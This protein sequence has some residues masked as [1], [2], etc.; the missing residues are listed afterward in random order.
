MSLKV[1]PVD[2]IPGD[3]VRVARAAFPKGSHAM[4]LRDKLGSVYQDARFA[5]LFAVRG[6]P[7]EAP[8]RLAVVTVLQFAEGLSDRQAANAVR[9]RIDWKYALGLTLDDPG[10]HYSVLCEFRGRLIAGNLE[11]LLLEELLTV[12]Q[13]H[14]LLRRRGRQRTDSTHILGALRVLSRLEQVAETM[15]AALNALAVTDP[16]WLLAQTPADW[17]ERYQRRVEEYRLP[18]GREAREVFARQVGED[19]MRLLTDL[20]APEAPLALRQLP[21]VDILRRT[22]IQ[23][24][25]VWEGQVRLRTPEEQPPSSDQIV[26]PYEDEARYAAKQ[27]LN[28]VGYKTHL[29]ETCDD[30][31]PHL[32]TD[33]STTIAPTPDVEQLA[34][35]QKR[36]VARALPPSEHFVD[37]GYVRT[38]N[39][40]ASQQEH[41]IDLIGPIYADRQWQAKAQ[42][43]FDLAH[44][45]IDWDAQVVT[46][47]QGQR[48][49]GW[50]EAHT[51]RQRT[52]IHVQFSKDACL[53][54]PVRAQ[55]TRSKT[56]PRQLNLRPR[57][58]YE[59]LVEV[60]ERQ[61]T[62]E[63]RS[64][65]AVRAGIEG[66]I[67]QGVRTF[68]L[69]QSRYRGLA[70][71][72]LQQVAT[73][74]ALNLDR[75]ARW[76]DGLPRIHVRPS[77]F[78]ALTSPN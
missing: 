26:S 17:F 72:H 36:L 11:N 47:P 9:G 3:T 13:T 21:A 49:V 29:T 63:F 2:A 55:C 57:A 7:A 68:D 71:T 6:R 28:W 48:S 58:E 60:R 56:A 66:T 24:F 43:G 75:L 23:R 15:R 53:A 8:W 69:R 62:A 4:Q 35:I 31:L 65:Y 51:A 64:Q 74:A 40:V 39:L 77:P 38:G 5:A 70:K 30:D 33:V 20:W 67:S 44:F 14:G 22:W 50:S 73:A 37:T 19:G 41:Q 52:Q 78:A 25:T 12:C 32:I 46:C 61:S 59:T 76:W 34:P 16:A 10:F 1:E 27:E 54:C 18:Q 45:Q 42:A